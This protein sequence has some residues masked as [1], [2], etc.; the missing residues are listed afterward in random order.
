MSWNNG[1]KA[2][3]AGSGGIVMNRLV[4]LS[5]GAVIY[6]TAT[7]TDDPLGVSVSV[8]AE[9]ESVSVQLLNTGG[10]ME[11]TA[12]GAI[13]VGARVFAAASGKVQALPGSAG[14]Y[15]LVGLAMQASAGDGGIIEVMPLNGCTTVTV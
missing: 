7:A 14:T 13:T 2:L 15:R 3:T 12:A 6:N 9:G 5:S 4:K 11:M 1:P 8:A 10:T